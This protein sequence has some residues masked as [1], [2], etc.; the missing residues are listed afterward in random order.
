MQ[1]KL[2]LPLTL[3]TL[4]GLA[5]WFG[6]ATFAIAQDSLHGHWVTDSSGIE[7]VAFVYDPP[8]PGFNPFMASD[9]DLRVWGFPPRPD[10]AEAVRYSFWER[11]V[12]VKRITPKFTL[13]NIYHG[14]A[15]IASL[16]EV[17]AG[18]TNATSTNWS[19]YVISG[20]NG[21]FT[22]NNSYVYS[23]WFVPAAHQAVGICNT[24]WDYSSQWV[25]F[26]GWGS[27]DVFQA[28]TEADANCSS[29][30]YYFWYEWYPAGSVKVSQPV[31]PGDWVTVEV[32]YTTAS[33]H[34]TAFL[35]NGTSGTA[36]SF[37]PPSGTT[38]VGNSAEWIVERPTVN[39]SLPDLANYFFDLF[40]N[41]PQAYNG[42][43]Y[44]PGGPIPPG[45]AIYAV[46]M[47]CP[48]WNPTSS[49]STTT[50]ISTVS[51]FTEGML[52]FE[53]SGPAY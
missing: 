33:P 47:I 26:D 1:K 39:G 48:P 9:E 12:T 31:G 20:A 42:H 27:N 17:R 34:G 19:G 13:T 6:C 7:T 50:D 11:L 28:G 36:F 53:A 45:G 21:L 22:P 46:D 3:F 52:Y 41:N 2:F 29:T 35:S 18:A 24:T 8:P 15:Q 14:P 32:Q 51:L 38:Y 23:G 30:D 4:F 16:G 44:S 43:S 10:P 49:C 5:A 37:N 40:N 25:G